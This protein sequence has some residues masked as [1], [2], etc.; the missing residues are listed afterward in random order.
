MAS[1]HLDKPIAF[2]TAVFGEVGL[3]GEIRAVSRAAE[4][5]KEVWRLGFKRCI[6]PQANLKGLKSVKG[7]ELVGVATIGDAI[8]ALFD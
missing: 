3:A 6:L 8:S 2:D 5:V 7:K 1:S 4:R